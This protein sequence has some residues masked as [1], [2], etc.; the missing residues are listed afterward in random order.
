[1]INMT[2]QVM[3]LHFVPK[4]FN[5]PKLANYFGYFWIDGHYQGTKGFNVAL[6]QRIDI[7]TKGKNKK[8]SLERQWMEAKLS[9]MLISH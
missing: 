1:M 3:N 8:E 2:F 9:T 6:N 5:F 7:A 4:E